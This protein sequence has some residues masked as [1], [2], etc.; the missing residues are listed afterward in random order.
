[1][2]YS[3]IPCTEQL[4]HTEG[5]PWGLAPKG[6]ADAVK[7]VEKAQTSLDDA[8]TAVMDAEIA[9]PAAQSEWDAAAKAAV[10][11][12]KPLPSRDPLDVA[13]FALEIARDD[14]KA[15]RQNANNTIGLAAG[16]LQDA[17]VRDAFVVALAA[18]A[19][20]LRAELRK[21]AATLAGPLAELDMVIGVSHF[22]GQ[23]RAHPGI[24]HMVTADAIAALT[25]AGNVRGHVAPEPGRT[26]SVGIG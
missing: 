10:R 1:M 15:A 23:W 24:P 18:R 16:Q 12:G 14:E 2:T 9:Q 26:V 7:A 21:Q 6:L 4:L 5:V 25:V 13:R 8:G 3:M 22:V 20:E 17:A 11:A 19:D